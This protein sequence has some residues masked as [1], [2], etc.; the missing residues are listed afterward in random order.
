MQLPALPSLASVSLLDS[1]CPTPFLGLITTR[2]TAL[3]LDQE[4]RQ[5]LPDTES[6]APDWQAT[7]QLL[8]RC[9]ALQ[10]LA[11]PC[12]TN[13]ELGLVAPALQQLRRLHFNDLDTVADGDAMVERL[14]S[15]PHLTSL[16]WEDISDHTFQRS[17]I[18]SPCRWKELSLTFVTPHQLARL[19][20]HS[21]NSPVAWT[22]IICDG[23]TSVAEVQAAVDNVTRRCPGGG[24]WTVGG[25]AWPVLQLAV[26][27]DNS[28]TC[29]AGE[30][31]TPA[32]LLRALQPLLAAPGLQRLSVAGL[33][34][35]AE[36]VQVLGQVIPRTCTQL[37]L[38]HGSASLPAC[39]QTA[40]SLPWLEMFLL[41][42]MDIHPPQAVTAYATA[43][44]CLLDAIGAD[45]RP[46]L[47]KVKVQRPQQPE[48]VSDEAH[49]RDWAY[50]R[51]A[52]LSLGVLCGVRL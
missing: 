27:D 31:D 43:A 47:A 44:T 35:D 7:L 37:G 9:T 50:V 40:R 39:V 6:P 10:S 48:A 14:L 4:Y 29:G 30:G 25:D 32:A 20:L 18:R 3:H 42:K 46:R 16:R 22:T 13:E 12:A 45:G 49:R 26:P 11:V 36:L 17:L 2:L 21:L 41:E 5:V 24:M 19:P 1:S 52:V 8:A 33:A 23:R 28:A 38:L 15:L 51:H 34:W